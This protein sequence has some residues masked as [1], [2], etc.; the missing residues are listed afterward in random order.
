MEI[1]NPWLIAAKKIISHNC[2]TAVES[3]FLGVKTINYTPFPNK[4]FEYELPIICSDNARNID[5][6]KN[7]ITKNEIFDFD[8]KQ[9]EYYVK[10]SGKKSFCDFSM[11]KIENIAD[12]RIFSKK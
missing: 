11:E 4:E 2:T 8:E 5:E 1:Y 6:L 12:S 10:N 9:V 3:A 7:L